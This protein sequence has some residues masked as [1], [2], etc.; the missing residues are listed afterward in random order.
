MR[1]DV[2]SV[3]PFQE[4]CYLVVDE[5]TNRAVLIDPGSEGTR[6]VEMV[7]ASGAALDAIWL[8]HAHIDHI[9]AIADVRRQY[10]VP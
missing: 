3:G 8:T 2:R 5:A 7:R 10:D 6:L 4:N 1:I 9:G